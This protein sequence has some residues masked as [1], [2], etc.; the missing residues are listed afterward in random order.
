MLNPTRAAPEDLAYMRVS[1]SLTS[2]PNGPDAPSLSRD[3]KCSIS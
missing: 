2:V 3:C 1:S